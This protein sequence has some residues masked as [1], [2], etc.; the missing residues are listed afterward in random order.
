[1][2]EPGQVWMRKSHDMLMLLYPDR[3][4]EK[5]VIKDVVS[6]PG[7]KDHTTVTY[8]LLDGTSVWNSSAYINMYFNKVE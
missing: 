2:I 5:I 4:D 8:F 1:M 3:N 7:W 6:Y